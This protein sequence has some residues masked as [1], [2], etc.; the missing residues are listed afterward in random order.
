METS[1]V[2]LYDVLFIISRFKVTSSGCTEEENKTHFDNLS[3]FFLQNQP[4]GPAVKSR[5]SRADNLKSSTS[6]HL[7]TVQKPVN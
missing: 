1:L 7:L 2:L 4:D 3:H 5:T 6:Q